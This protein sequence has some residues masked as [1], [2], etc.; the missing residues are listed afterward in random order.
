LA[1]AARDGCNSLVLGTWGCGVLRDDP[2]QVAAAF[3]RN[4]TS[5]G[6]FK[7]AFERIVFAVLDTTAGQ[8]NQTAIRT[9][10]FTAP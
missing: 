3:R 4:L 10:Q 1:V 8:S 9:E 6:E 5:G 2:V 7:G